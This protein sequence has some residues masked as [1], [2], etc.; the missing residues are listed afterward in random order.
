MSVLVTAF[1]REIKAA[2]RFLTDALAVPA[3]DGRNHMLNQAATSMD[4]AMELHRAING[5]D[6]PNVNLCP[7]EG[8]CVCT[9][10][11]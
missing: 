10:P 2:E 1:I 3:G 7:C 5:E 11:F 9:P 8:K 4:S 6:V